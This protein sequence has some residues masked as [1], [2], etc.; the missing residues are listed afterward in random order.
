ML[1]NATLYCY[2]AEAEDLNAQSQADKAVGE[3]N[4]AEVGL[5]TSFEL[6]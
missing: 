4:I 6:S 1:S 5:Y 2:T 3:E